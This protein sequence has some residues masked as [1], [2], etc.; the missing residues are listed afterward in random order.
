[1][2]VAIKDEA[3]HEDVVMGKDLDGVGNL[4][5]ITATIF[6]EEEV[7]LEAVAEEIQN[8]GIISPM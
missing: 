8:Q 5:M 1:M 4:V 6:K 2:I 3:V 7:L